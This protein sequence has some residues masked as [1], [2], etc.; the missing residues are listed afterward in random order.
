MRARRTLPKFVIHSRWLSQKCCI[1][2]RWDDGFS[3]AIRCFA[4]KALAEEWL[5][6]EG[7]NWLRRN[8]FMEKAA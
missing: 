2:A 5:A 4:E 7:A 6:S 3:L 8:G 1:T